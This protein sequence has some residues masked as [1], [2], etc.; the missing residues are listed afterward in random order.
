MRWFTSHMI[1][2]GDVMRAMQYECVIFNQKIDNTN[3]DQQVA[4]IHFKDNL[5]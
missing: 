3:A 2:S 4:S 5:K 1:D